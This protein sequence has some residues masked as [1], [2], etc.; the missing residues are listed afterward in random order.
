MA[1]QTV[2][3]ESYSKEKVA[4]DLFMRVSTIEANESTRTR[5]RKYYFTLYQQCLGT[6]YSWEMKRILAMTEQ[7][8]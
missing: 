5:D 8:Q 7:S 3:I 1:D 2:N 6:V 4:Y